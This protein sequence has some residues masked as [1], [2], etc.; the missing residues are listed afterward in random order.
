MSLDEPSVWDV[1]IGLQSSFG[2]FTPMTMPQSMFSVQT[3][4]H[5]AVEAK[6]FDRPLSAEAEKCVNEVPIN[7]I[8]ERFLLLIETAADFFIFKGIQNLI[9]KKKKS[10]SVYI[11]YTIYL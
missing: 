8:I 4:I 10:N 7:D 6:E 1:V 2:S 11:F 3:P 5:S 9:L